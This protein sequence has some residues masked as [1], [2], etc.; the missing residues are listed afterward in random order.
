MVLTKD[1][2][3]K[4]NQLEHDQDMF[5]LAQSLNPKTFKASGLATL[6]DIENDA[7]VRRKKSEDRRRGIISL[8]RM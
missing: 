4:L 1:E 3:E 2:V 7:Y 8:G 6:I 5:R